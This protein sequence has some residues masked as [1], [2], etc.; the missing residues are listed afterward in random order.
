MKKRMFKYS[1]S[2]EYEY[3]RL[4]WKPNWLK[5]SNDYLISTVDEFFLPMESKHC[6]TDGR[7][8]RTRIKYYTEK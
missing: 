5:T 6:N 3:T 2:V 4:G 1:L 7:S 8:V